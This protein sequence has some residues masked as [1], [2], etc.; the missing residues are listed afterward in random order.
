MRD[1]ATQT[2]EGCSPADNESMR[3][4]YVRCGVMSYRSRIHRHGGGS[5]VFEAGSGVGKS[6]VAWE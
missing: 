5:A 4:G 2:R 6:P 1:N 3:S